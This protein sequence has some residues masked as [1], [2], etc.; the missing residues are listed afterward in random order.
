M[1]A[2]INHLTMTSQQE[3]ADAQ[4]RAEAREAEFREQ[5]DNLRIQ[6][7]AQLQRRRSE[8]SAEAQHGSS[9]PPSE[10]RCL[11]GVIQVMVLHTR[12]IGQVM[13]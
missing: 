9:D 5:I 3:R 4:A 10:R 8:S 6:L 13:L 2:A 12:H 7:E 1:R 11:D